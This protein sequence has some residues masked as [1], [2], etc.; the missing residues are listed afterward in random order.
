MRSSLPVCWHLVRVPTV[1][2]TDSSRFEFVVASEVGS[3]TYRWGVSPRASI[4]TYRSMRRARV[5]GRLAVL[6]R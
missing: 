2:E 5:S 1:T 6:M 4:P 3:A